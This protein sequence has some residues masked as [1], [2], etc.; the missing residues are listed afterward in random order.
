M[1]EYGFDE[2]VYYI[3]LLKNEYNQ[4]GGRSS[5]EIIMK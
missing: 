2:N 5:K 4:N 3:V 1:F